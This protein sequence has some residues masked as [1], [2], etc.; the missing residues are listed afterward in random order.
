MPTRSHSHRLDSLIEPQALARPEE[1]ELLVT[2]HGLE[3]F[4][5]DLVRYLAKARRQDDGE[6]AFGWVREDF[7]S[8]VGTKDTQA[9][10]STARAGK[11]AR[12]RFLQQAGQIVAEPTK[13]SLRQPVVH[14][15]RLECEF[16]GAAYI[17]EPSS[18]VPEVSTTTD[19]GKPHSSDLA[20]LTPTSEP[21]A[22]MI[23]GAMA[24]FVCSPAVATSNDVSHRSA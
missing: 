2:L 4:T 18:S 1:L 20:R 10:V 16:Y 7:V 13:I 8:V 3:D 11:A 23:D 6:H 9:K 17:L 5:D 24:P 14:K 19:L 15:K 22:F 21:R 12:F